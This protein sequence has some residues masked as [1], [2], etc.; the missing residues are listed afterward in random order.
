[1]YVGRIE[2]RNYLKKL[3]RQSD[4]RFPNSFISVL[5]L[6]TKITEFPSNFMTP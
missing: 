5:I 4:D 6:T 2:I 3:A 1:M